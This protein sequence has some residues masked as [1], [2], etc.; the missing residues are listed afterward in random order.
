MHDN[1]IIYLDYNATAPLAA[2]AAEAMSAWLSGRPANPASPHRPGRKAR[3]AI[4]EARR[5][6]AE[7]LAVEPASLVFT[8]GG[9]EADNLALW[10]A[11]GWPPQGHLIVSAVEHPAVLEPAA[12]L[13]ALGVS[14]TRLGVDEGGLVDLDELELAFRPTTKL[15][16]VMAANHEVGTL[17]P[18][19]EI[20]RLAHAHGATFH[21]DAVQAAPWLD[22][23]R[24]A[25]FTDL[26]T[27]SSHKLAGPVGVGA[28]FVR[29]QLRLEPYLRGGAQQAGRRGGTEPVALARGFAAACARAT[30]LRDAAASRVQALRDSFEEAVV[31]RV[32]DAFRIGRARPRLPNTS[33]LCFA[34]CSGDAL[35]ARLDLAGVAAAS[36]A[37]CSSGVPEPSHVLESMGVEPRLRRG[38]LRISLGYE[39][40][41]AEVERAADL[42]CESVDALRRAGVEVHG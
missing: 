28:L 7:F 22:M 37:A 32:P 35:V 26:L 29:P 1:E 27:I 15:V 6:L 10:G 38:A 20:S 36:G 33:H 3:A 11:F 16:S 30:Q 13:E 14:V 39:T 31:R 42:V 24:L 4:E 18:V 9:T 23:A 41:A 25:A 19:E 40:T 21:C 17:Q 5:A 8:S 12:A 34:S 2:E